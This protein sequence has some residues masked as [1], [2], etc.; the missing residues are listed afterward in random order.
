MKSSW[1]DFYN[2]SMYKDAG[3]EKPYDVRKMAL[4]HPAAAEHR[5]KASEKLLNIFVR[6]GLLEEAPVL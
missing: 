3:L 1:N 6:L 5:R 2:P 4:A